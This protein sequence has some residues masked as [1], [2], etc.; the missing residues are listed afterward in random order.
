M[1]ITKHEETKTEEKYYDKY[2]LVKLVTDSSINHITG[3]AYSS[4]RIEPN[5][6]CTQK[7]YLEQLVLFRKGV[8][9]EL[10][11]TIEVGYDN[12]FEDSEAVKWY[13]EQFAATKPPKQ[14]NV[15]TIDAEDIELGEEQE[16]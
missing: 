6:P 14:G 10:P 8:K 11:Y 4:R 5:L 2:P 16:I 1:T 3:K 9:I 13:E 7:A 12:R 15:I